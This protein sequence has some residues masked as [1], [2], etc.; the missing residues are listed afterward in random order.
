MLSLW[1][2]RCSQEGTLP[3]GRSARQGWTGDRRAHRKR[4][5]PSPPFADGSQA[6]ESVDQHG[7]PEVVL[8]VWLGSHESL[9]G[10]LV[11]SGGSRSAAL[12][13]SF[14]WQ[15]KQP[16][17]FLGS[18][19]IPCFFSFFFFFC[20]LSN[21]FKR[22][23]RNAFQWVGFRVVMLGELGDLQK[24]GPCRVLS[25]LHLRPGPCTPLGLQ[26]RLSRRGLSS[27]FWC[28]LTG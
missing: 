14:L 27:W 2:S 13:F 18:H 25:Q 10:E 5:S 23:G 8:C 21:F 28:P 22:L 7:V 4:S 15:R 9:E 3:A 11:G 20:L 19:L 1:A 6:A 24:R 26:D 17:N 16:P 12:G